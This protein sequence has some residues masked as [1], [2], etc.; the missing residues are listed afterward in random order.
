MITITLDNIQH[1]ITTT[2]STGQIGWSRSPWT[3]YRTRSR[4]YTA[5]DHDNIQHR[6]DWMITITLDNIQNTITTI[7]STGQIGWS[8]SPWTIQGQNK[9]NCTKYKAKDRQ[10][11]RIA[12][13]GWIKQGLM[14]HS[15]Q[16]ML[17]GGTRKPS[18]NWQTCATRKRAKNCS[19]STC[20]QRCR[21]QYWPTFIRLAAVASEI[22]EIPRNSLKIQT[23]EVQGHPRSSILVPIEI[24]YVTC[25]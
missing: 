8:R 2:Y 15:A 1:R 23:Y 16:M 3:I 22:C 24:P 17:T 13:M 9:Q 7:Y 5:Q 4:Q 6:T 12:D 21:W 10:G 18:Y 19:N 20:L 11:R 25:Y 14:S